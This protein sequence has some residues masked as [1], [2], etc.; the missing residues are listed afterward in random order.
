MIDWSIL[1]DALNYYRGLGYHYVEVPWVVPE[2]TVDLTIPDPRF[3]V[4]LADNVVNGKR[5]GQSCM[6]EDEPGVLVGSAEQSFLYMEERGLLMPGRYLAC[7]PCFR[8]EEYTSPLRRPHFMKV[9]LYV[10]DL[11][12]GRLDEIV[13]HAWGFF[14]QNISQHRDE[15]LVVNTP[16]G[17]DIEV[18]GYEVGSYGIRDVKG[19]RWAY[20][21]GVAEPRFSASLAA[22]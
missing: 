13:G 21:T 17:F 14:N 11:I 5:Y 19:M 3:G 15:L 1:S 2:A 4:R 22:T 9:E 16:D 7:T 10:N 12:P 18:N 20:G 8:H 6:D